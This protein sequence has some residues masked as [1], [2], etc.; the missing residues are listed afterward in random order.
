MESVSLVRDDNFLDSFADLDRKCAD[1][2][3]QGLSLRPVS[4][5]DSC[6]LYRIGITHSAQG[7][8]TP[9][10]IVLDRF[11]AGRLFLLSRS[12]HAKYRLDDIVHSRG[13]RDGGR[14]GRSRLLL[15]ARS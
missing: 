3:L 15:R 2:I 1:G 13:G 6:C 4:T 8:D 7:D 11:R 5:A 14:F 10:F 9:L 12:G